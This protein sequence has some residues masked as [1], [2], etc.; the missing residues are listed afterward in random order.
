MKYFLILF[1]AALTAKVLAAQDYVLLVT[2]VGGKTVVSGK[3]ELAEQRFVP[4]STF[5]VLLAWAALEEGIVTPETKQLLRDKHVPKTPR[6]A[7][8]H[9]AMYYSSNDYFVWLAE[10]LGAE[11][12]KRYIAVS[13]YA[14]GAVP[15]DWPSVKSLHGGGGLTVTPRENHE[16]MQKV[17]TG[18]LTSSPKIQAQLLEVLRWPCT[19]ANKQLYGKTG[20]S[21]G[22]VWFNGFGI[23]NGGETVVTVFMPGT[24][25]YR[26]RVIAGFYEIFKERFDLAGL[27]EYPVGK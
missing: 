2:E 20:T 16:F 10:K 22:A 6:E 27:E 17:A 9:E 21:N 19:D 4:A 23:A 15:S 7:D 11:K 1:L 26:P 12:L 25:E 8:L 24:A 5:K 3:A 13:G 18:K 14:G